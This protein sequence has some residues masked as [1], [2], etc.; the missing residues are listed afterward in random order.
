VPGGPS[1]VPAHS[2]RL[3]SDFGKAD[4]LRRV[5][6]DATGGGYSSS[7][8]RERKTSRKLN[9]G[10]ATAEGVLGRTIKVI[11]SLLSLLNVV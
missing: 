4:W 8:S 7:Q 10:R 6:A 9:Q 11:S 1:I 3:A 2:K 5:N